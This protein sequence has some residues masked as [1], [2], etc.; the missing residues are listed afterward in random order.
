MKVKKRNRYYCDYC[1]KSGGSKYHMEQHE[2]HCTMNPQRQ[3]RVCK[4]V[5]G[6]QKPIGELLRIL[7]EPRI[8][9]DDENPNIEWESYPGLKDAMLKLRKLTEG[10]PACMMAA[11]RQK[12]IPVPAAKPEFDF[13]KEMDWLWSCI[14]DAQNEAQENYGVWDV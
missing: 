12:G 6:E 8:N 7:P 3:C 2:L 10:C 1:K 9:Y 14:N 4:M 13:G 11:L 5:D